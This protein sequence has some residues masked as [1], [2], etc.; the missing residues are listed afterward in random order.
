MIVLLMPVANSQS[1]PNTVGVEGGVVFG[2]FRDDLYAPM[3]YKKTGWGVDLLYNPNFNPLKTFMQTRL[4]YSMGGIDYTPHEHF[5]SKFYSAE[6]QFD[7]LTRIFPYLRFGEFFVGGRAQIAA[8][9]I[10]LDIL[11]TSY[12]Y[13]VNYSL[14]PSIRYSLGN[15]THRFYTQFSTPLVSFVCRP[16][17]NGYS[18]NA[19][20]TIPQAVANALFV[21]GL[22]SIDKYFALYWHT[23]YTVQLSHRIAI[24]INYKLAMQRYS[25]VYTYKDFQNYISLNLSYEL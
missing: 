7:Y 8:Q 1:L 11:A 24:G 15:Q 25:N 4:N 5:K 20:E 22:A 13:L 3:I 9:G 16:P 2:A 10:Y 18:A 19:N 21:G 14:M 12:T 6:L 17:T 23:N